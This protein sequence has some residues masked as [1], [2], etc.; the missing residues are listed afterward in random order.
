MSANDPLRTRNPLTNN[1]RPACSRI[2]ARFASSCHVSPSALVARE[3][4]AIGNP[5]RA[6]WTDDHAMRRRAFPKRNPLDATCFGI[7]AT[8]HAGA[9]TSVPDRAVRRGRHVMWMVS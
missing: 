3:L 6:V 1:A 7:E 5:G 8:E 2:E 4:P 9:L